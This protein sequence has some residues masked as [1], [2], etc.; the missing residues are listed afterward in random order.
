ML[1]TIDT[2]A[3]PA[4]HIQLAGLIRR[5]ITD[6]E[7]QTGERLPAAAELAELLGINANTV[8]RT[9]RSLRAERLLEFRRGRGVRVAESVDLDRTAIEDA[10][11]QVLQLGQSRGWRTCEIAGLVLELG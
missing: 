10:V 7:L 9:Y 2:S 8:L 6:G 4:L 11:R 5:A 3:E 1:W